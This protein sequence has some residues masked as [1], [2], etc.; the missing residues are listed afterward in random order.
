MYRLFFTALIIISIGQNA[1]AKHQL[2]DEA[3]I[4]V[5]TF[6]PWQ[7][8]LWSAFGH[9]AFRVYDPSVKMDYAYNYG[10]F[11]FEPGFYLNFARG[12]NLY[13]LG[14]MDY[15]GF[16]DDYIR[17]N[18]YIHEQVLNLT[19]EQKQKLF[20]FLEWNALPENR[21]YLYDYFYDNCATRIRD[22]LIMV[23]GDDIS[24][25]GFYITTDYSI[26]NLTDIYLQEQ[27]WGDLGI[28]ICLGLP[29]DKKASP[30]EYMFLPDYVESGVDHASIRNGDQ[31]L[32][33]VKEKI[34][35]NEVREE[36]PM[37]RLPHPLY[38]FSV[39]CVVA[40]ALTGY[41]IKRKKLSHWFDRILFGVCG[42][43]GVLLL[44]L[45]TVTDHKAAANN[46]NLMWAFPVNLVVVFFLRKDIS[47]IKNYFAMIS[48][49]LIHVLIFWAW[50]PQALNYSLVPVVIA[51]AVRSAT[52]FF[53]RSQESQW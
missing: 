31:K 30:L 8:E 50:L 12:H 18:R 35:V 20:D 14:V 47:T 52:Q 27:P 48:L 38:F 44:L 45:W 2:S 17:N 11:S 7:G 1:T 29:M 51:L 41:D 37:S 15:P 53:V 21:K 46:Y 39:L 40:I 22:V 9:S 4:S 16:R 3:Y 32:D 10:I 33:L 24:F 23:F 36:D 13:M 19:Q 5:V 28:D 34:I 42:L 43:I 49:M 26:R 6:G 25:D